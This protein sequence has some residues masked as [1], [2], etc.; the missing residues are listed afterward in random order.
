LDAFPPKVKPTKGCEK[1][2]SLSSK[3][4]KL[5]E[6]ALSEPLTPRRI[7]IRRPVRVHTY[8][9]PPAEK[10]YTI[11]FFSDPNGDRVPGHRID[12][13]TGEK[14]FPTIQRHLES[15]VFLRAI[16]PDGTHYMGQG[17][18]LEA[19]EARVAAHLDSRPPEDFQVTSVQ[20]A[21]PPGNPIP[22]VHDD[23][24]VTGRHAHVDGDALSGWPMSAPGNPP[25]PRPI[26][27]VPLE[28]GDREGFSNPGVVTGRMNS[29]TANVSNYPKTYGAVDR[30]MEQLPARFMGMRSWINT[31]A[32]EDY[33]G[34]FWAL[35]ITITIAGWG[36]AILQLAI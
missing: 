3:V 14:E 10:T 36:I 6:Q 20:R 13:A 9:Q 32:D 11:H 27:G 33:D 15:G 18:D 25:T 26:Q 21:R 19:V 29:N 1:S 22:I 17:V 5:Y 35:T 31:Q 12:K 24:T 16:W 2:S 8:Q 7:R 30:W 23:F 28:E 34:G 4:A